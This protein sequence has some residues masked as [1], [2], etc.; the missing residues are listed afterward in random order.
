MHANEAMARRLRASEQLSDD[1]RR[2]DAK[3]N[4]RLIHSNAIDALNGGCDANRDKKLGF[5]EGKAER[6]EIAN[7]KLTTLSDNYVW[8]KSKC[9]PEVYNF[10][11]LIGE[12]GRSASRVV[13]LANNTPTAQAR[14]T[15]RSLSPVS[16]SHRAI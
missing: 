5:L 16:V 6:A 4:G 15:S 1:V 14:Q 8:K 11:G 12:T 7:K 10:A 2:Q 9:L 3:P 13:L